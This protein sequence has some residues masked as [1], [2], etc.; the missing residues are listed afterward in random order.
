MGSWL[1]FGPIGRWTSARKTQTPFWQ[2]AI[3]ELGFDEMQLACPPSPCRRQAASR[4]RSSVEA[5]WRADDAAAQQ[6]ADQPASKLQIACLLRLI[7]Q[8][9]AVSSGI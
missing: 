1:R 8:Q 4:G 7:A 3:R 6:G 9:G 2:P 5:N